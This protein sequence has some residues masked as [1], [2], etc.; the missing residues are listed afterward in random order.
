[1]EGPGESGSPR[2]SMR[3]ANGTNTPVGPHLHV[4][5]PHNLH[6]RAGT[7]SIKAVSPLHQLSPDDLFPG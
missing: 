4:I 7:V 2:F 6:S 3:S 5:P 1:M